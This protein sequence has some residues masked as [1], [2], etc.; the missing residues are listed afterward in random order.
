VVN[1]K[2][3]KVKN[4]KIEVSESNIAYIFVSLYLGEEEKNE[5]DKFSIR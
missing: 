5:G 4:A 3:A 2:N 1:T